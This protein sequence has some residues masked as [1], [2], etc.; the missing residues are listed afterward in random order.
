MARAGFWFNLVSVTL[1]TLTTLFLVR[2]MTGI[3]DSL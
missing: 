1:V 2:W 3:A